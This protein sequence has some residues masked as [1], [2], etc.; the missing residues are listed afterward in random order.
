ML[1]QGDLCYVYKCYGFVPSRIAIYLHEL[2][3][4]MLERH[5]VYVFSTNSIEYVRDIEVTTLTEL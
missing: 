2:P 3:D 5:V 1:Q 4:A